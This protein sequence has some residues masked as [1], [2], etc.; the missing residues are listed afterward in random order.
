M[1]STW[2]LA[3]NNPLAEGEELVAGSKVPSNL[4]LKLEIRQLVELHSYKI[5]ECRV[6]SYDIIVTM[7]VCPNNKIFLS[8]VRTAGIPADSY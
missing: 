4:R 1:N 8:L 2:E 6:F 5:K 7:L 3:L